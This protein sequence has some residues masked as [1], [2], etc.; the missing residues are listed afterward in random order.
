[1]LLII[2]LTTACRAGGKAVSFASIVV[3]SIL[4]LL[5]SSFCLNLQMMLKLFLSSLRVGVDWVLSPS[6]FYNYKGQQTISGVVWWCD[7]VLCRV[8]LC[9]VMLMLSY[10]V[11]LCR[12]CHIVHYLPRLAR[13]I[14][15][16]DASALRQRKSGMDCLQIDPVVMHDDN[17]NHN[18]TI[19]ITI[20]T[21]ITTA[22]TIVVVN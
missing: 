12:L 4:K 10:R 7:V 22:T 2:L 13:S 14:C 5:S 9:Y 18:H 11:M 20:T 1:M 21:T 17:H 3:V 6:N 19:T 8:M 16:P 15:R